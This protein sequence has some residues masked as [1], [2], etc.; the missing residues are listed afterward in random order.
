MN[1]RDCAYLKR[2][3][4]DF[5]YTMCDITHRINPISCSLASNEDVVDMKICYNCMFW[6]GG[7]DW[8]LSCKKHYYDCNANGFEKAC[9]DFIHKQFTN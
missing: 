7:G 2:F 6:L 5:N 9:E 3:E 4:N 1:C 8:G